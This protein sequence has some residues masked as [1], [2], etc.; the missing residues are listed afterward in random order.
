MIKDAPKF[1]WPAKGQII[2]KYGLFGKGQHYD[3]IDI[4]IKKN[5]PVYS[6]QS[7][8][9][10]FVGSQLKKFG[11]LI[12]I[13]HKKGWLTAYSNVGKYTVKQGDI[14]TKGQIISFG[15]SNKN[16]FHF[17]IRHNRN[18]VNPINYLN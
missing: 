10:A 5:Q 3:G 8:K 18:P 7:G 4:K 13:K 17:Q 1:T 12:L 9:V 16:S 11:N 2:K 15:A 14:V 6:S